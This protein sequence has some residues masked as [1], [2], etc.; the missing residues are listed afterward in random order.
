MDAEPRMPVLELRQVAKSFP[1]PSGPRPVLRDISL[2]LE[3][4]EFACLLG[5]SGA[6][7]TT[8][9]SLIAG[10]LPPDRGEILLDGK[11]I[12]GPGPDRGVVFQN[13]SLLPWMSVLQ[14]VALAVD[15][16]APELPSAEKTARAWHFIRLVHLEDAAWKRP[17][18]LSGGMRQRVAVA[19]GL[20][21]D[22]KVLLLD[23]PFSAL[24][25]L[26]RVS[27]Q[28][29]LTRIWAETQK[30][31]VMITNDIDEAIFLADRVYPLVAGAGSTLGPAIPIAIPRPRSLRLSLDPTYQVARREILECLLA[32]RNGGAQPSPAAAVCSGLGNIGQ[33]E[34]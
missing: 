31:I 25:A 15:A 29:E 2:T 13:Y 18:E 22:P 21:M 1:G 28:K 6:G 23:E 11:P 24:D 12:H 34:R 8:L 3:E 32:S 4:G 7:K 26:T 9:I 10:L 16:V 27:L 17:R 5:F 33:A 14:N 19:R 20:A 30:T